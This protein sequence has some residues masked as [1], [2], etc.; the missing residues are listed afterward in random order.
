MLQ[1]I[2][3]KGCLFF[4]LQICDNNSLKKNFFLL[5]FLKFLLYIGAVNFYKF[6]Y[7]FSN[8]KTSNS[9]S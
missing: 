5:N 9:S 6:L 7:F 4:G 1:K 8:A 2:T 3:D